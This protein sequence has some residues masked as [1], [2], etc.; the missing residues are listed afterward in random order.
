[1][2]I[3]IQSESSDVDV[4]C[5]G[6]SSNMRICENG[7][8]MNQ[9]L[10]YVPLPQDP[11][12]CFWGPG[13]SSWRS[14]MPSDSQIFVLWEVYKYIYDELQMFAY[15][16]TLYTLKKDNFYIYIYIYS[17]FVWFLYDDTLLCKHFP[18]KL[19]TVKYSAL[20]FHRAV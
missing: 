17:S 7:E 11:D 2:T 8:W 1:M 18:C 13:D 19:W 5:F 16:N 20:C 3:L 4:W 6:N 12:A 15:V 14:L 9:F 10:M